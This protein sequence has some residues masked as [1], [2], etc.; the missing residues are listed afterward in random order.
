MNAG[1]VLDILRSSLHDG[2]GIRTTVFLKG[3]PLSC[4]WCHNP[5]SQGWAPV[6]LFDNVRCTRCGACAAACPEGAQVLSAAGRAVDRTRCTA[7]GRCAAVCPARALEVKG[8][9]MTVAQVMDEVAKDMDYYR[10][11]GGGVTLS[12]GEPLAQVAFAQAI[13]RAARERG[14]HTALETCGLAAAADCR[15]LL[16]LVDLFLFDCKGTDPALHAAHTGASNAAILRNLDLLYKAGARIGL[17]CP[18]VPGVNDTDAHLAGIAALS[19]R[20]PELA[21]IEIMP[22]HRMGNEK[23]RRAGL[24]AKLELA[25]AGAST[26]RGWLERLVALGCVKA[27]IAA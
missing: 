17:R 19:R 20:Y 25:D 15:R 12:G 23:A 4:L 16:P 3:C 2:P 11:T 14:I 13:L 22:Y 8:R 7:C 21:G 26:R 1:L 27:T 24:A 6:L 9:R 5:E 18:L 10:A